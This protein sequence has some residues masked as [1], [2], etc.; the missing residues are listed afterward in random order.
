MKKSLLIS[1][2]LAIAL[3]S[4]SAVAATPTTDELDQEFDKVIS[5][6]HEQVQYTLF[7]VDFDLRGSWIEILNGQPWP[8]ACDIHYN[9]EFQS[10][11]VSN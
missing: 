8:N 5:Q 4:T 7:E 1:A 9:F 6:I 11:Q 2:L 10:T 3:A